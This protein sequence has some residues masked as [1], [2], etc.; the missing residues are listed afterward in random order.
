MRLQHRRRAPADG[1]ADVD[2]EL[3]LHLERRADALRAHGLSYDDAWQRALA[4]FGDFEKTRRYCVA[5]DE[6]KDRRMRQHLLVS[7]IVQD[8]RVGLRALTRVPLL[9]L[10]IIATVGIGIGATTVMF[11]AADAAIFRPLPYAGADQLFRI[12]TDSPP[13]WFRFSVADYLALD[14][15]QT[16]FSRVAGYT[17]RPMAY[18]DGSTAERL[19]TRVAS[20]GYFDLLEISPLHG[21]VFT[22]AD[23]RAGAAPA[24]VVS[25]DFWKRRLGSDVGAVGRTIRLDETPNT[26]VGVLGPNPGPLERG[27]DV[28]V[29]AHWTTP[30]RRG[31]F[32]ITA[33]GR[34]APGTPRGTAI[35]QLHEITRRI[36][37]LWKSSYQNER[38]TWGMVEL[39][40]YL[41]GDFPGTAIVVAAVVFFVWLI[42]CVN[43]SSLLLARVAARRR[44]LS[45][46]NALGA[47]RGRV[48]VHLLAESGVLAA[49]AAV[50]GAGFAWVGIRLVQS[51]ATDYVPRAA[52]ITLGGRT[53]AVLMLLT[54]ASLLLFG[55]MPAIMGTRGGSDDTLRASTRSATQ[56]KRSRRLGGALVATQF[57]V[58]TPMLI[59]AFLLVTTLHRL[60]RI[61]V[62]FDTR[63][64]VTAAIALPSASYATPAQAI[65][66]WT[67]LR[68]RVAALPGAADVAFVDSRPPEDAGNQNNFDLEDAPARPGQSQAVTTWVA[69]TPEYFPLIK[70]RAIEGRLLQEQDANDDAPPV[71]VVDEAWAKRFFPGQSAVGKRLHEGGCSTCP[72][73]TVVGV[74]PVVKYDRLSA[75]DQ[76]TVYSP[77][78]RADR[79]RY[80]MVRTNGDDSAMLQDIRAVL[81][82]LDP[83]LPMANAA[84]IDELVADS[85]QRP[86]GLS[87]LAAGFA[88]VALLLSVIGI[89]SQM[90]NYVQQHGKEIGIRIALGGRPLQVLSLFVAR[91]TWLVAAGVLVGVVASLNVTRL[92]KALLFGLSATDPATYGAVVLGLLVIAAAACAIPAARA[93]AASPAVVLRQE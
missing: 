22:A 64:V 10:T 62:G 81:R 29:A 31:P 70:S 9:A 93:V 84:S 89:Y 83:G 49:A 79:N 4:E 68:T 47:S 12:F 69:V 20:W 51:L 19:R 88:V 56:T 25:Y 8:F 87:A 39:Q 37:P 72:W 76:G 59:L 53:S 13:Y 14:E 46:R 74:V 91:G 92:A 7:G 48:L 21:R 30:P 1:A 82:G 78:S 52:E 42:A 5:Q 80:V 15:Q 65:A 2:E 67:E 75:P 23:G 34:L 27:I 26:V 50:L 90:A 32:F 57:A 54:G 33:L 71:I 36:F 73:T 55:L 11:A 28:F 86:A 3:R 17:D 18:T 43:A 45:V 35:A 61:P 85:L 58:A 44:E 16:A 40:R 66:F 38:A 41:A 60:E 6:R 63:G 77:M 24:V